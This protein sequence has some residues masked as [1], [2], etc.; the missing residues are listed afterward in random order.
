MCENEK[1]ILIEELI[2]R[3]Y[4]FPLMSS[5]YRETKKRLEKQLQAYPNFNKSII[6]FPT[7]FNYFTN[8]KIVE[9]N[10][11]L[12]T[13]GLRKVRQGPFIDTV[14]FSD[15][16]SFLEDERFDCLKRY[17]VEYTPTY[18]QLVVAAY[19]TDG[20]NIIL[21]DSH[22]GRVQG[23]TMI[24]GHVDFDKSCYLR[25]QFEFLHDNIL[26]EMNEEIKIENDAKLVIPEYPNYYFSGNKTL[27]QLEHFGIVYQ[28]K[29]PNVESIKIVSNEPEKHDIVC[30]DIFKL[31]EYK[32]KLDEW[33]INIIQDLNN[34]ITQNYLNLK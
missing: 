12:Q 30:L 31:N 6:C 3:I 2:K 15:S 24:Q 18:K 11:L 23:Y 22:K 29:V 1:E 20:Q 16:I 5:E 21:L 27:S 4:D 25:S 32:D 28:I 10:D 13:R 33:S 9:N 17:Q 34:K 7:K 26:R 19:I 14:F 8:Y